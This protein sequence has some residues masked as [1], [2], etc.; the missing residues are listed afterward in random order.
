[1]KLRQSLA[2]LLIVAAAASGHAHDAAPAAAGSPCA[3][4]AGVD[5]GTPVAEVPDYLGG[6][7]AA[8]PA[9]DAR[10]EAV[11]QLNYHA[12]VAAQLG[13]SPDPRD[14]AL[15]TVVT[16]LAAGLEDVLL[17]NGAST[18]QSDALLGRALD[19]LPNDT[20]VLWIAIERS[21][22]GN[23]LWHETALARLREQEADNAAVWIEVLNDAA[24][25][26]DEAA[27]DSAL[28]HM[29]ASRA[30][31]GHF[32]DQMKAVAD[33]YRRFPLPD[34]LLA[35]Q[36]ARTPGLSAE[37]AATTSALAMTTALALP[38][39][40]HLVNACRVD[41]TSGRNRNRAGDCATIG[42]LLASRADTL[43]ASRI[44]PALLRASQTYVD[45]DVSAARNIDWIYDQYTSLLPTDENDEAAITRF[46]AYVA[47]W[48]A[49]GSEVEA[50]HRAALRAGLAATPPDGWVD[51][52]S[53]FSAARLRSARTAASAS[54]PNDG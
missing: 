39:F 6:D 20:L 2:A 36:Q 8:D 23:S 44:G 13:T 53:P 47:D 52:L 4:A 31:D 11:T 33:V 16:S 48:I 32:V 28:T 54:N 27:V 14:W 19:A 22:R 25:R 9:E 40:Q 45:A 42:R 1:M 5:A 7:G 37:D 34:E 18:N 51:R 21:N 30:F 38:G 10:A 50:M 46:Q 15:A 24:K 35:A 12:A 3:H 49:T 29:A 17:P 41:P 43:L 26:H